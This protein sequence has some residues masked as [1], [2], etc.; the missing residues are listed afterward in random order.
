[1][2]ALILAAG[3][4]T[5][6][7]PHTLKIPKPLFTLN[8]IPILEHLVNQLLEYGCEKIFINTHHLHEQI[9]TF[10]DQFPDTV[11]TIYEPVI[12]DTGGAIANTRRFLERAPFFVINSDIVFNMDLARLYSS[13][14]SSNCLA[15]LVL[16]DCEKFNKVSIDSEGYIQSFNSKTD[17]FAFT[18]IQ[19]LSPGIFDYFPDQKIFSSIAVYQ[20]LIHQKKIKAFVEKEMYWSEIGTAE[21]YSMTSLRELAA[22]QFEL[23][24]GKI[25]NIQ[26]HKLAGDGSDRIWYRVFHEN[27][28]FIIGD[29]GICL[30]DTD[31]LNQL[32]A[33]IDIGRHLFSNNIPVPR[34]LNHDTVSGMVIMDDLGDIHLEALAKHQND[35]ES[36]LKLYQKVIDLL[37]EFSIIG[38]H[39]FDIKWTCQTATY[40]KE[41]I[42]EKECRYFMDAFING[43]LDINLPFR[44]YEDEF[45]YIADHALEYGFMGLMHRDC[46][47]RN[48]MMVNGKPFF[49]DFQSA[50]VGPFQYDLASLLMDP[51]V[52][53]S[54]TIKEVLLL[55]TVEKLNLNPVQGQA[56]IKNYRFCC[57]TR[58]FQFLGAFSYLSRI[59]KKIGFEQYIPFAVDLL[60]TNIADLNTDKI[61]KL[62]N[63]VQLIERRR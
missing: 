12:L 22:S 44:H 27:Q 56:F 37:I 14:I 33:F 63:L 46:Q 50:R 41:L 42:L 57:L 32:N 1:M 38:A 54:H 20:K 45:Q 26:V 23:K 49:I 48:I 15:T 24:Q 51:Y 59:K 4:G 21:S 11:H 39:G 60:K 55:Y 43:Y 30:P 8:S 25:K 62:A 9:E 18:G 17:S 61:P 19:V 53:L 13:H 36:L 58:N 6:L 7:L 2:K 16:H 10:A 28:S 40:S 52:G 31:S 5:R 29:H 3:Y 35:S 47:S 34:I